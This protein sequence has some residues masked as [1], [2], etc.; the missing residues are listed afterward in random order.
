MK[1]VLVVAAVVAS[2]LVA[3][4]GMVRGDTCNIFQEIQ[5][6][7]EN[8]AADMRAWSDF[9]Y[10]DIAL[11]YEKAQYAAIMHRIWRAAEVGKYAVSIEYDKDDELGVWNEP[12]Q[13]FGTFNDTIYQIYCDFSSPACLQY[14]VGVSVE[15]CTGDCDS[16]GVSDPCVYSDWS[17]ASDPCGITLLLSW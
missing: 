15:E 13:A 3:G 17:S 7:S 11:N 16:D 1:I 6:A 14:T 5:Y 8:P 10:A 2:V 12:G 9:Y 4:C